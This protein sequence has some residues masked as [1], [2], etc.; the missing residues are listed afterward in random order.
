MHKFSILICYLCLFI[1]TGCENVDVQLATEAG[2]DA[3]KAIALTD[4]AVRDLAEKSSAYADGQHRIAP[5]D[6]H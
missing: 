4:E 3:V 5:V 2:V 1:S 6:N